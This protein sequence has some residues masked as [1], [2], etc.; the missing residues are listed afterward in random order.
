M[1]YQ[2]H[3]RKE[4][5]SFYNKHPEPFSSLQVIVVLRNSKLI[6]PYFHSFLSNQKQLKFLTIKDTHFHNEKL[7]AI[8][9]SLK[10]CQQ[11]IKFLDLTGNNLGGR[12]FKPLLSQLPRDLE[13]LLLGNNK[14]KNRDLRALSSTV[15]VT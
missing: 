15:R 3:E 4:R 8:M 14:L 13:Y 1:R 5:S 2:D 7:Y 6:D 11:S 9:K 10:N 12:G